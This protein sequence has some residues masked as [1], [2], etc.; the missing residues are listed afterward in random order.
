M[1]SDGGARALAV[2]AAGYLVVLAWAMANLSYDIWG[3][4]VLAPILITV[5]V[6]LLRVL[7][8]GSQGDLFGL[9]VLGLLAKLAGGVARYWVSFDAYGGATDAQRYH[10]YA[11]RAA[12]DVWTGSVPWSNILP[13]GTGTEFFERFTALVYSLTGTSRLGGF[14]VFSWLS[15]WGVAFFVKAALLAV[16]GLAR[17]R[18]V[19]L[20]TL[21]PSV[22][23]WPSSIGKEA[24]M[25]LTLGVGT[26]G[27]ARL[28][29]GRNLFVAIAMAGVG[30][31][32]ALF[33]RPHIVGV[34]VAGVIPGLAIALL[35]RPTGRRL[36]GAPSGARTLMMLF[37]IVIALF[38][39]SLIAQTT[40]DYLNPGS[41]EVS[42]TS[43]EEILAETTRRTSES[44]S[45][46]VPPSVDSPADWPYASIRTLTRPL[47]FE[48][49]GAGQLLAAAEILALLG[50]CALA[51]RRLANIP[52]LMV[53]NPYVTFALT[54]L[55][56]GGLAYSSFA[57][58]GVLTRQKSLV[59]PFLTLIPCLPW[60]TAL[61]VPQPSREPARVARLRPRP[62][63]VGATAGRMQPAARRRS[64]RHPEIWG[65]ELVGPRQKSSMSPS[66]RAQLGRG[67]GPGSVRAR[68][69]RTGP[70]PGKGSQPDDIWG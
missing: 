68:H 56:L 52:R 21:A 47:L 11:A 61:P 37:V 59:Y 70:P 29:A 9:M 7:F 12:S 19:A 30:F 1:T 38:G 43:I 26:F 23:F 34:W 20:T 8:R 60:A 28:L 51:W 50:L 31:G 18:Y 42:A 16:P 39:M 33:V 3:A 65:D 14:F 66:D 24:F 67:G 27:V 25:F 5:G 63:S 53:V 54:T 58:L 36:S 62:A 48:A 22:I 41:D 10:A 57:N 35:R 4:L 45:T 2:A 49:R 69:V 6:L 15:F 32:A 17:R 44:G 64:D 40:V 13:H 46:F 55:F